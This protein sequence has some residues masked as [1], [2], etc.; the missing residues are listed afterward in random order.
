MLLWICVCQLHL[1]HTAEHIPYLAII[2]PVLLDIVPVPSVVCVS[3]AFMEL[4][5]LGN[6]VV[7]WKT[8]E[9]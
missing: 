7:V 1:P 5:G 6:L 8:V 3:L 4:H 2:M 9:Q